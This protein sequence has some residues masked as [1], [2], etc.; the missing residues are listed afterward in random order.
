MLNVTRRR[1]LPLIVPLLLSACATA[2]S[3]PRAVC[4]PPVDYSADFQ[5]RLATEIEA[6]PAGA[7][8]ERAMIDYGRE[9]AQLRACRGK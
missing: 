9:R 2:G 1:A 8:L 5:K 7:A 6:L 3:D 4:P